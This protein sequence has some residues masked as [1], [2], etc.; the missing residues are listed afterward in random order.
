MKI[1]VKIFTAMFVAALALYFSG[2]T[3]DKSVNIVGTWERTAMYWSYSGSPNASSNYSSGG[4][5]SELNG[6]GAMSVLFFEDNT[7]MIIEKWFIEPGDQGVDT[8]RFIYTLDGDEG[9]ITPIADGQKATWSTTY[10]IQSIKANS[11][12]IYEKTVAEDYHDY[13]GDTTH[14]TR[15]REQWHNCTKI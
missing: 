13:F 11:L 8:M 14:Y 7:G 3:K 12:T 10:G 2:C 1:H 9:I 6:A 4:P 15:I 5:M